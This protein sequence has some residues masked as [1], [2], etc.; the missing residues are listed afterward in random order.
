MNEVISKIQELLA[1]EDE[2]DQLLAQDMLRQMASQPFVPSIP[3]KARN[4]YSIHMIEHNGSEFSW[5][6]CAMCGAEIALRAST[7][8]QPKARPVSW[9]RRKSVSL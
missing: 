4:I 2:K 6:R 7:L 9:Y 8:S 3:L 5:T 1:S